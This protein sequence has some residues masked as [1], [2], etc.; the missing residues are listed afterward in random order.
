M[1]YLPSNFKEWLIFVVCVWLIVMITLLSG[2]DVEAMGRI[3]EWIAALVGIN[4]S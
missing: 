4:G 1:K 2:V 3:V